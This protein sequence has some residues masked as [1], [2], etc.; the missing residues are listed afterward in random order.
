MSGTINSPRWTIE[1]SVRSL[2]KQ[3]SMLQ[4]VYISDHR[5]VKVRPCITVV[6]QDLK[7]LNL[8]AQPAAVGGY[9]SGVFDGMVMIT[10][11]EKI[12]ASS[13]TQSSQLWESVIQCLHQDTLL[14]TLLTES[15]PDPLTVYFATTEDYNETVDDTLKMWVKTVSLRVKFMCRVNA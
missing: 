10:L 2:L 3:N 12:N 11:E 13:E 9:Q 14:S 7:E 4:N 1:S 8:G 15:I 5:E 6:T